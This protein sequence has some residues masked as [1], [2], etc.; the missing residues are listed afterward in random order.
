VNREDNPGKM[1]KKTIAY[2]IF[3]LALTA[4]KIITA[5]NAEAFAR[6]DTN[7]IMIGD[8]IHFELGLKIPKD[9]DFSWPLIGDTLNKNIE[10]ISR[11]EVDT[12]LSET[13]KVISQKFT[14]TSFDSG[15]F[16]LPS[17]TFKFAKDSGIVFDTKSPLLYLT[18]FTPE[19]DTAQEFKPIVMPYKEPYTFMEILPWALGGLFIVALIIVII[20]FFIRR[21]NNKPIF[22]AKPK[23]LRP[24]DV[25][26][27][28]KL[29][30]LRLAKV[31]QQGKIKEFHS[32]LT[33]IMRE[34]LGRR[35]KFDA[36][37]MTSDEISEELKSL[38][39]NDQAKT[40]L[41]SVFQLSDLVKFAKAQPT[42]LEHDLSLLHCVD[43]VK[44]TKFTNQETEISANKEGGSD[45]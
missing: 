35:F 5:Q 13:Q 27:L 22:V 7:A 15:Y 41:N 30:E 39:D 43:F 11:G 31:W 12:L 9:F 23:P 33:D 20:W 34:Y 18:V 3:V 32:Q 10:V 28:E 6:L 36:I 14:I 42:A 29:D 45:V 24:A 38:L 2:L 25:V 44:E 19:V 8:Q 26:A 21:K 16:E 1:I 4:G 17:Y 40:K 37:E